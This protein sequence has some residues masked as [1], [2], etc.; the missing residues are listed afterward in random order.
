MIP[1]YQQLNGEGIFKGEHPL[2]SQENFPIN[3]LEIVNHVKSLFNPQI[4]N[5]KKEITAADLMKLDISSIPHLVD[6]F[7]QKVGLGCLA[8]SSDTG[9]STILRQL[10]IAIV[11]GSNEFLGFNLNCTHRSVIYVSTEDLE[12]E[13]SFLL[14]KQ[15]ENIEKSALE[16]LRFIFETSDLLIELEARL[17]AMPADLVIIDCFAD[18]YSRDLMDSQKVREFLNGY[19]NLARNHNC[20]ILFLHHTGKRTESQAPSKNNLLSG[21]G[22]E[23]KM[24]IVVELRVD[25]NNPSIR[26]WCIVKG[27]YLGI[28]YK[29]NSYVLFF[30]EK[31]FKFFNTGDRM[32]F[33]E[34]IKHSNNEEKK[35]FREALELAEAGINYEEI[36][37]KIGFK[38]KG[39]VT[40]LLQKGK[41][42]GW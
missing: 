36:A 31:D 20:L 18:V 35:K 24:R 27:N 23:A 26:H 37:K 10:A 42:S 21:Q 25:L 13:T 12:S 4:E 15:A 17:S 5:A 7:F 28:E 8:G 1:N 14:Q 19:Q 40:K 33:D 22:L 11:G 41:K 2:E 3:E 39:S 9:K 32:S 38:S 29:K 34:I 6:P 16:R 30:E